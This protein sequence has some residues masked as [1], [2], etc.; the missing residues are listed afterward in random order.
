MNKVKVVLKVLSPFTVGYVGKPVGADIAFNEIGVPPTTLKGVLRASLSLYLREISPSSGYTACGEIEP[1]RI[2]AAHDKI[3]RVCDVCSLFGYPETRGASWK[4]TEAWGKV[5]LTWIA[6]GFK[7]QIYTM[8]RISIDDL[9]GSVREN[10]LFTQEYIAP[11][12]E[13][14]FEAFLDGGCRELNLFLMSLEALRFYR[15]GRGGMVD[16]IV[17][18]EKELEAK[19]ADC[20]GEQGL[21]QRL[22]RLS[23]YMWGD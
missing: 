5:K 12:T 21:M 18:N 16:L 20:E 6:G 7:D 19:A 15:I 17:E 1:E 23:N 10:A 14:A 8:T 9:T 22:R 2:R 11:G 4:P 3:G 13:L